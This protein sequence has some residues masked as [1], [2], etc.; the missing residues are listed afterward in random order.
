MFS[1]AVSEALDVIVNSTPEEL[2]SEFEKHSLGDLTNFI[3][4]LTMIYEIQTKTKDSI[5]NDI[6]ENK[7]SSKDA[8]KTLNNLYLYMQKIEDTVTVLK[9][10]KNKKLEMCNK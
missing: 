2:K 3:Q 8:E 6:K 5:L 4:R 7:T 10:V 1:K 9:S